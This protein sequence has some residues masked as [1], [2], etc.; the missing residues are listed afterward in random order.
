[1]RIFSFTTR[2]KGPVYTKLDEIR[3]FQSK[4]EIDEKK[5]T[6]VQIQWC[7]PYQFE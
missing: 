4:F 2:V 3:F 6:Y 1:M 5:Y 7:F